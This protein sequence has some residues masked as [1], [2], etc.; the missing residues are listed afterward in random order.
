MTDLIKNIIPNLPLWTIALIAFVFYAI[1]ALILKYFI[2][3]FI[4]HLVNKSKNSIDDNIFDLIEN[5]IV[6]TILII[7]LIHATSILN[8]NPKFEN[9]SIKIFLTLL[10]LIWTTLIYKICNLTIRYIIK[11]STNH[12][13]INNDNQPLIINLIKVLLLII[14]LVLMLST[15]ELDLTPLL[16]SA[17]ILSVII[18]FAAKDTIANFLGGISVIID[19]PYRIGDWIE[20]D[21]NDRGEVV[22]IGLRSTRIKTR[23]D[24]L[25]SIPNS[26]ISN[27]KIINESFPY[28]NYRLRIPI[29][30][31]FNA[32]LELVEKE[33]TLLAENNDKVLNDPFPRVRF[34]EFG[35]STINCEL[36]CWTNHPADRGLI[37]HLLLKEIYLKFNELGI[38]FPYQ[39]LDV[40]IKNKENF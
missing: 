17:G 28:H 36:L 40:K 10:L 34:R 5:P 14:S 27:A 8:Y 38:D 26:I 1:I 16:A 20:L 18:G 39:Q 23:D 15:W 13:I 3:R 24:V 12:S 30:V 19:K 29:S 4:G 2:L 6:E 31:H 11:F 32:D 7:G 21:Q 33:L 9:Y 22:D 37:I 35:T 25:I